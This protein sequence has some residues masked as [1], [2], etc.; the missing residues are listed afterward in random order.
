MEASP[1]RLFLDM[2]ARVVAVGV[3]EEGSLDSWGCGGPRGGPV[4][5]TAAAA[6]AVAAGPLATP[7]PG[8]E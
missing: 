5:V 3:G 7:P 8:I 1:S 2:L 6:A 4:A